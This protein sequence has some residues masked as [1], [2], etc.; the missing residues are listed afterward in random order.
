MRN[1]GVPTI[2]L[3][4]GEPDE[5]GAASMQAGCVGFIAK[6]DLSPEGLAGAVREAL[7]RHT[8]GAVDNASEELRMLL[9]ALSDLS[10]VA[11]MKPL[12]SRL[13]T[14]VAD[15][16]RSLAD[17]DAAAGQALEEISELCLMLWMDLD[18]AERD[19]PMRPR[20]G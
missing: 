9:G 10:R 8:V 11:R 7:A 14:V 5:L 13:M 6:Q 19:G 15:L 20:F 4:G 12:A 2:M 16:R 3:S 18:G 1:A 17:A